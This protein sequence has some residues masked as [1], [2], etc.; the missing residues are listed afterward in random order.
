M[1]EQ[2]DW[3]GWSDSGGQACGKV[4]SIHHGQVP[5]VIARVVGSKKSPVARIQICDRDGDI[6][7]PTQTFIGYHLSGLEKLENQENI[8]IDDGVKLTGLKGLIHR[9]VQRSRANN[10]K[11]I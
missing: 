10:K 11:Q 3:V 5:D 4:V 7:H 2:G 1:I 6:M 8:Q 9:R